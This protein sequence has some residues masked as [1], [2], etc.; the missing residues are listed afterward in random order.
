[1]NALT[2][3]P[4]V[5][6][7]IA[8]VEDPVTARDYLDRFGV[9]LEPTLVLVGLTLGNDLDQIYFRQLPG[10]PP[11][12][13]EGRP[14][15]RL[16]SI[17]L[18]AACRSPVR[19]RGE[20]RPVAGRWRLVELVRSAFASRREERG[21]AVL[22]YF[23]DWR[24]PRLFDGNG[25]GFCLRQPPPEIEQALRA[26]GELLSGMKGALEQRGVRMLL[27]LFPQ[28]Y[29]VQERDWEATVAAYGLDEECFERGL[30][31]R[32]IA[33]LARRLGIETFDP[34]PQLVASFASSGRSLYLPGGDMH[35]NAHGH[36]VVAEALGSHL[37][38][39]SG[40]GV[41]GPD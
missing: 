22:P 10:L 20:E 24:E 36:A 30:A 28:R 9:V 12:N 34:T 1:W 7:L 37:E 38:K 35:W 2:N 27:L 8:E 11:A 32:R 25:L 6:A 4:P 16:R 13:G 15:D 39:R 41:P 23:G 21:E 26:T 18:P 33:E 3:R 5:E 31:R 29:E 17:L 19:A 40:D 14:V